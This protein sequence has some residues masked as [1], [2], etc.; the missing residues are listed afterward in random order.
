METAL[1]A[2][3]DIFTSM[4][5][6][7]SRI[8]ILLGGGEW[9]HDPIT[10]KKVALDLQFSRIDLGGLRRGQQV[11]APQQEKVILATPGSRYNP[12]GYPASS[13]YLSSSR[14]GFGVV[15]TMR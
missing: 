8:L 13:R 7:L 15:R 3:A 2:E 5:T 1:T 10:A 12:P 11:D 4:P 14:R 6:V 9:L